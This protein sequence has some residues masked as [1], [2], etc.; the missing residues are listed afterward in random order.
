MGFFS[1]LRT[2]LRAAAK[3][4][5]QTESVS[6]SSSKRAPETVTDPYR[7]PDLGPWRHRETEDM[8]SRWG[9]RAQPGPAGKP[10]SAIK[11]FIRSTS[12]WNVGDDDAAWALAE[13]GQ[14]QVA[15]ELCEAIESDG[16]CSGLLTTRSAGLL[17]LQLN[18]TGDEDLV[19]DLAGD[20]AGNQFNS[21][22][23]WRMFPIDTLERI[24]RFGILLG[25]GVGYFVQG[26]NDPCPVLHA[27]EHQYLITRRG[28]DGYARLYYRTLEGEVEVVPGDGRWFVFAPKGL[29]RF[30][31]YGAWRP[32]GKFWLAKNAAVDQRM[33]WGQK[34]ARGVMWVTAPNSSTRQERDGVVEFLAAA[35]AP[36]VM[37]MLEGWSLNVVDVQGQGFAV[38]KDA[39]ED[40]NAEIRMALTGQLA[41]SGAQS[42]GLGDGK[43]FADIKQSFIDND[44]EVLANAI[45]FYG[46]TP[47][48]ERKGLVAPWAKWDTTPPADKKLLGEAAKAAGDGLVALG[49]GLALHEPDV[50]KRPK[51]DLAEY[52]L[53]FGIPIETVSDTVDGEVVKVSGIDVMIEY[54]EGSI[55]TGRSA[56]GTPW[57]T[58]MDGAAYG[59]IVGTEG[60]DGEPSDAYVGPYK[61]SKVVF[62]L[63]Q[64]DDFGAFDEYK[65]FLGFASLAHA[66][67]VYRDLCR[68]E[69]EGR[70]IELPAS[71]VAGLVSGDE[72][73][74]TSS[75]TPE[76]TTAKPQEQSEAAD[77]SQR[78]IGADDVE[79]ERLDEQNDPPTNEEAE[80]LA[81]E[82]TQHGID[83]CEHGR[84]NECPKCGV[85]RVRGVLIGPDGKPSGWKIAWRAIQR[86]ESITAEAPKKYD[87]IDFTPPDGAREEAQRG[88]NWR[89]E[90]GRGGTEVGVARARDIS[91]GK[92]LSPETVRR[93]KAFFDRHENGAGA[94]SKPGEGGFPSAWRI[95]WALWGGDAGYSWAKKVVRQMENADEKN[96]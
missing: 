65:F 54:Q 1:D 52:L 25:A 35:I 4:L 79:A 21:G 92:S 26:E 70:W 93:M 51:I 89:K 88:L 49:S 44:A 61:R 95:A 58:V 57:A 27:V 12:D 22:L 28:T 55:R 5:L 80:R 24:I 45:H 13:Q 11:P 50:G 38:W 62:V 60:L 31:L 2:N 68:P 90:H 37:A 17:R 59:Y 30:W 64:L 42:L 85:E 78:L 29:D 7:A 34:L 10:Y 86:T 67:Y 39:K 41:T 74:I 18:I 20:S 3:N 77:L 82:M 40:A 63:E 43:I 83:R 6:A 46:L 23:F 48:A 19:N 87:H 91:N 96:S 14:L 66:Q 53:S 84:I 94:G 69:L 16:V 81:E 15:V 73:A 32:V 8:P 72:S 71:V 75:S 76:N 36:P 9:G 47:Y 56:S 33:T